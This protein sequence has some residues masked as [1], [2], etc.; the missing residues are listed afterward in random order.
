VAD[1]ASNSNPRPFDVRTIKYLVALMSRHDLSE[2]DLREGDLRIHL[3]RGPRGTVIPTMQMPAMVP[4]MAPAPVVAPPP[5]AG[6]EAAKPTRNLVEIK[7]EHIGIFYSKPNPEA[8]P[9]VRVGSRVSPTTV[10]GL[11]EAMKL[12]TEIQA[13]CNGII[14]EI[15]VENQQPIEYDQVLFRVDPTA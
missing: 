1:E 3:L 12:Y 10:V 6:A 8:D 4:A 9:Y 7:S 11:A 14:S 2:I 13:G 15:L 5:P